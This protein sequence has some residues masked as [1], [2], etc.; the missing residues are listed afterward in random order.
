MPIRIGRSVRFSGDQ[1]EQFVAERAA[2]T[3][4]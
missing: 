3:R 1:L 4:Q 2:E